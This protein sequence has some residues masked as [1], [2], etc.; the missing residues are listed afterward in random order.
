[1]NLIEY[2]ENLDNVYS[3]RTWSRYVRLGIWNQI[4]Y[5]YF[6]A[7]SGD[8][9]R[10]AILTSWPNKVM[11]FVSLHDAIN[12]F[13]IKP[14]LDRLWEVNVD[15]CI[16]RENKKITLRRLSFVNILL[17]CINNIYLISI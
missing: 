2:C 17:K 3:F 11:S 16:H 10:K 7:C 6:F 1:M 14:G 13:K 9:E 15:L 8:N 5:H 4:I 12:G